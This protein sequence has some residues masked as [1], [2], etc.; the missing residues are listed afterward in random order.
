MELLERAFELMAEDDSIQQPAVE[1]LY[2][3]HEAEIQSAVL[4]DW[5]RRTYG[6]EPCPVSKKTEREDK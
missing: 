3:L 1:H 6:D 5:Y 2:T 4:W